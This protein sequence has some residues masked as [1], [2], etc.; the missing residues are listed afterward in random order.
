MPIPGTVPVTA[1]IAPTATG[2]V[3]PSHQAIYGKGGLRTVATL[4]ERDSIPAARREAGM[5]VH[6]VADA[7]YWQLD[8]DLSNWIAASFATDAPI[9][10]DINTDPSTNVQVISHVAAW[11]SDPSGGT[12]QLIARKPIDIRQDIG[13]QLTAAP[14]IQV[15]R[16][17]STNLPVR[18]HERIATSGYTTPGDGG[19]N[20]FYCDI[21]DT[22]TADN[23][24]SV[25]VDSATPNGRRWK[26]IDTRRFDVRQWGADSKGVADSTAAIQ[27]A[28]DEIERLYD[29]DQAA[30]LPYIYLGAGFY[31][32]TAGL[33]AAT[34]ANSFPF[35]M[36]G[37]GYRETT[38]QASGT[39]AAN[40]TM[41]TLGGGSGATIQYVT[42]GLVKGIQFACNNVADIGLN[43]EN[44]S[45]CVYEELEISRP[46]LI[47]M[48]LHRWVNRVEN[49]IFDFGNSTNTGIYIPDLSAFPAGSINNIVIAGCSFTLYGIGVHVAGAPNSLVIRDGTFDQCAKTGILAERG[50]QS[51]IIRNNY[52]EHCGEDANGVSHEVAAGVFHNYYGAIIFTQ[53]YNIGSF[54]HNRPVICDNTFMSCTTKGI[55]TLD[56]VTNFEIRANAVGPAGRTHDCFLALR[57]Q[58]AIYSKTARNLIEIP[59]CSTDSTAVVFTTPLQ[60]SAYATTGA[61]SALV[62]HDL[63]KEWALGAIRLETLFPSLNQWPAEGSPPNPTRLT[64]IGSNDGSA[65][66]Q[67]D[68]SMT[69]RRRIMTINTVPGNSLYTGLRGRYFRVRASVLEQSGGG[70]AI[71]AVTTDSTAAGVVT[72]NYTGGGNNVYQEI[73]RGNIF[74]V[75]T[76]CNTLTISIKLAALSQI[77]RFAISDASVQVGAESFFT[78][79]PE[80]VM[81]FATL[82]ELKAFSGVIV[83]PAMVQGGTAPWDDKTKIKWW[84]WKMNDISTAGDDINI[85]ID[86]LARRWMSQG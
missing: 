74:Y 6:V 7:S 38:I 61:Y 14:T 37:E 64:R 4:T 2:D 84:I 51:I 15:L 27:A 42:R 11:L 12:A 54:K 9:Q 10:A 32:I 43:V 71:I 17:L 29:A 26:Q 83:G 73:G 68:Q 23:G 33:V 72:T 69:S 57:G 79:V 52:F 78:D 63:N 47:G 44:T 48:R 58:G 81:S 20:E 3:Y 24:G 46:N 41:L 5:L 66:W 18:H 34:T 70:N 16:L 28:I 55:I 85:V 60:L 80:R 50:S 76:D 56:S 13:A 86:A 75:P 8:D 65:I 22:T 62:I 19:G 77:T 45:Y 35:C 21:S 49:C 1:P 59:Y 31:K 40:G 25:I 67:T 82:T 30:A 36:M 53:R 39:W